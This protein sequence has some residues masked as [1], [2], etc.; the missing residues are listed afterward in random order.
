[1]SEVT[2]FE[3]DDGFLLFG[4]HKFP[5]VFEEILVEYL[6]GDIV[7]VQHV[8]VES[9]H[10]LAV[11]AQPHL[12]AVIKELDFFGQGLVGGSEHRPLVFQRLPLDAIFMPL[13]LPPRISNWNGIPA[14]RTL[15]EDRSH[16][17]VDQQVNYV[18]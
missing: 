12:F 11:L 18:L 7:V 10:F 3:I 1:M 5:P 4:C 9:S 14:W 16:T 2:L 13:L 15:V 8:G 6:L 17:N